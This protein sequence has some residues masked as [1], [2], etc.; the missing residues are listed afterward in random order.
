MTVGKVS[1][2]ELLDKAFDD[3]K[4]C[5]AKFSTMVKNISVEMIGEHDESIIII[6][7]ELNWQISICGVDVK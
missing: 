3:V 6:E 2:K 5:N 1:S 7:H 4:K